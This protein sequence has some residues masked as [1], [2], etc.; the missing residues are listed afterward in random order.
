MTLTENVMKPQ[1]QR[2]TRD[3]DPKALWQV[4][5]EDGAVIIEGF[6]PREVIQKFD[7]ELDVRSKATKGGEMNQ[8]FYQMPGPTTTKWMNDLTAT[9]PTFRHEILNNVILHNL[10][11]VAFEPHGDYWLLNGMAMEMMPG[12]PTQQIHNDHGTH[13]ILQYLRP[14]A[15]SPVFSIITAVTEFTESNGATRVILGSHRWPQG[16][17]AKDDQAV[18][19]A[20]Q[21]G[22][23]LVMHRSTKHGGAAHDA[24][25][26]DHRRLLLTCMG[27][28][29][30]A[31][32]ETNVTVPRPIVESM[33]PLAQKMIG[34]RSTRPVISN[35]TGLN[36]VRMKHL[37]NQI[38]LKSN[39][40]LKVGGC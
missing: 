39:V 27:T 29:Q 22:D 33:T 4:V 25:N 11:N 8:E 2:F 9:C 36:T 30:L 40:P 26:Q 3:H 15:P 16:Q 18:R 31:P 32:Y 14:D 13:P 10:C 21:P 24:D 17:K 5:E 34:W 23:A 7:C 38:E 19:A 6:L 28:C 37:E 20:L 1:I 35:V 12:N